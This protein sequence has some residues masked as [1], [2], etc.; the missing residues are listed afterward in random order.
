MEKNMSSRKL[1]AERFIDEI[2]NSAVVTV[3]TH[4]EIDVFIEHCHKHI[5]LYQISY[6]LKG[7]TRVL[8][9]NRR[10]KVNAGDLLLIA[11]GQRH[12]S[13]PEEDNKKF[14]LL[15]FKFNL[16][17]KLS[18]PCAACIHIGYPAD[19]LASFHSIINEFHMRRPQREMIMRLDLARLMLFVHRQVSYK[20]KQYNLS[21]KPG[22]LPMKHCVDKAMRYMQANYMR[23]LTL[24]EIARASGCSVSGI[25]HSFKRYAGIS[26]VG[27]L[28]NWRLSKALEIM[29]NT[30]KKLEAIS[31][32]TGFSSVHYFSR[33]FRK[34]YNY[35][36]R[37]YAQMIYNSP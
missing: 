28:I 25:E 5:D 8:I 11:P 24:P 36:P 2:V 4:N 20:E 22:G 7:K 13:G 14:E 9:G 1:P 18:F 19:L 27:Y 35:S 30:E 26:P 21:L 31:G 17:R 6:V 32:E 37:R 23:R 29:G 10:Y 33:L 3:A 15:Q 34:R 12:G 16:N